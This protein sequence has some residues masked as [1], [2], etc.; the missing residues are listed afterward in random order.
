M[1]A[2]AIIIIATAVAACTP[3]KPPAPPAIP[4]PFA[5]ETFKGC[6]W[7]KVEGTGA[8]TGL[9]IWSYACGPEMGGER[10]VADPTLPGFAIEATGPDGTS[11]RPA[12]RVFTKTADA[13]L[14][15]VLP[16]VRAASPGQDTARCKLVPVASMDLKGSLYDLEPVGADKVAYDKANTIEPGEPPCGELGIAPV[17]DR[18]FKVL[19]DDATKVV[20]IDMGSEIQIF[21][22]STLKSGK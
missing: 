11:R 9:S 8:A 14:D 15:S 13:S 10:L 16:A 2:F 19:E 1:R 3:A 4:A 20:M 5:Q 7:G 18:Y 17:G 6:T 22:P 21:D 12:I